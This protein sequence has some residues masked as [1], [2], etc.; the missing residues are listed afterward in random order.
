[1]KQIIQNFK[2]GET[3]LLDLPQP[4][5]SSGKVLIR[6][7]IS[8][9]SIGTERM[10]VEFGKANIFDK[11]RSQPSKVRKV[12]NKVQSEGLIETTKAVLNK[13]DQPIALGYCNVGE[14]IALGDGVSNF[15]VGDRVVS[16]GPHAE[17]VSVTE[18]LVANIPDDVDDEEASFT[19]IGS[20]ALHGIRL[21]K[22]TF[23]ETIVVVG[24]GVVGI[25]ACQLLKAN[26]CNVIALDL[27]NEKRKLAKSLGIHVIDPDQDPLQFINHKTKF[28]A[29]GV[30]I[31]ASTKSNDVISQA[32]KMCR[33]RGRIILV[34][35]VGLNIDRSE[36]YK[37][38]IT[39]QVSCSYGPGRYDSN[40]EHK[41][42]D[43]PVPYV[44]WTEKRNFEA[45]LSAISK[46]RLTVDKL[47]TQK[48]NLSDYEKIYSKI[49]SKT[50]LG[51][52]LIYPSDQIE[53]NDTLLELKNNKYHSSNC[54]IGIIGSG[55]F[56]K[57]TLLPALNSQISRI[58]YLASQNGFN[59]THLAKKYG[60][61][62]STTDYKN[63]LNDSEVDTVIITT[64]HNTHANII[65]DCLEAEKNVFVEKPLTI[66]EEQLQRVLEVYKRTKF[67]SLMVG[68]NR[69]FSKHSIAIKKALSKSNVPIN[70]IATMNA[71]NIPE[72]HWVH[73]LEIGGG[74]IIGEACHIIDLC[75][76][77]AGSLVKSVCA[78]SLGTNTNLKSDNV[79]IMLNFINGSNAVI[80]YFSNGSI[81]YGKEKLELFHD[82]QTWI[83][84]DFKLTSYFGPKSF[85]RIKGYDKGHS[86]Q[87]ENYIQNIKQGSEYL[88]PNEEI[89]N[90]TKASF[91]I[92]KSLKE[93]KWID[94]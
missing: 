53:N 66:N 20:I 25:I 35:V 82:Q 80:N 81:S 58:K 13:L 38:E 84:D 71:G 10:L 49:G 33:K 21:I 50:L 67:C 3:T 90:V 68:F 43:Y 17:I 26:G 91:S 52:I 40:Y 76:F 63:I 14:V 85:R 94:I 8:L 2:T 19:I 72:D 15:S 86:N 92:L 88:I 48:E 46:K 77:L 5:A 74:R 73:D 1:M 12:I 93:K 89:I 62:F 87:F 4:I 83:L 34:G 45:I 16:N 36:F 47:I 24:L 79:S 64:R 54:V 7:K 23:G 6:T 41:G 69:R 22:P 30:L 42:L 28:G 18:N 59:S 65:I 44:R 37:K 61:K 27:V 55:N 75:V 60:I 39:F 31:T 11:A 56:T 32:A 51:S 78:N 57:M 70:I 9:V 29:D